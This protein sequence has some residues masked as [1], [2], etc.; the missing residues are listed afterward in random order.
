MILNLQKF[1]ITKEYIAQIKVLI[2]TMFMWLEIDINVVKVLFYLMVID[3]VL[4]IIK[5]FR[6]NQKFSFKRLSI[7]FV[8]K[9]SVLLIPMTVALIGKGLSYDFR[10]FVTAIMNILIVSDG[11]SIFSNA[12]AIRNKKEVENI[13]IITALLNTIRLNLLKLASNIFKDIESK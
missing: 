10:W 13:D 2:Y 5:T 1:E 4:G 12:I 7:G 6:L 11:I 8:S 3:T 9:L